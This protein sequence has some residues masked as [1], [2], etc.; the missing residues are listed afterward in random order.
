MGCGMAAGHSGSS[1]WGLAC[2]RDT[3]ICVT[4]VVHSEQPCWPERGK[5]EGMITMEQSLVE[6]VRAG[7]IDRETAYA[8]CYRTDDLQRYLS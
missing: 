4:R 3:N 5:A 6:L 8:H 2:D 7:R 1:P